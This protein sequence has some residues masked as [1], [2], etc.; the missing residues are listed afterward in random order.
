M[1]RKLESDG[2]LLQA[3]RLYIKDVEKMG[4]EDACTEGKRSDV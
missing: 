2:E 4:F 1:L 3:D